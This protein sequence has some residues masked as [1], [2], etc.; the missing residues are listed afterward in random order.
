MEIS[1]PVSGRI[2]IFEYTAIHGFKSQTGEQGNSVAVT[3]KIKSW[4]IML[5]QGEAGTGWKNKEPSKATHLGGVAACWDAYKSM[6][7]SK[8]STFQNPFWGGC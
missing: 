8:P 3:C 5:L 7:E 6:E 2:Q 1:K 4:R